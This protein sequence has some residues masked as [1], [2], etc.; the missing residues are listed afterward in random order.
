[1][2]RGACERPITKYL[3]AG[4]RATTDREYVYCTDDHDT[5]FCEVDEQS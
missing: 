2:R 4:G 3:S 1:L 5:S